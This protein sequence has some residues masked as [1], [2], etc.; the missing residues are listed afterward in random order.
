MKFMVQDQMDTFLLYMEDFAL[1]SMKN[2]GLMDDDTSR[3]QQLKAAEEWLSQSLAMAPRE[4]MATLS[5]LNILEV[6]PAWADWVDH[7]SIKRN[8]RKS[9]EEPDEAGV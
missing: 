7:D 9:Q 1:D 2:E 5:E 8:K 3:D 4:V 6:D